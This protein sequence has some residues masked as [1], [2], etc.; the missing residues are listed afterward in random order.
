MGLRW[1]GGAGTTSGFGGGGWGTAGGRP[2]VPRKVGG[3]M[4]SYGGA[5]SGENWQR[6]RTGG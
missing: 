5:T 3:F 1:E 4:K 2:F 6:S